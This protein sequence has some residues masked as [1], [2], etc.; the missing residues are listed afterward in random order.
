[1]LLLLRGFDRRPGR[2]ASTGRRRAFRPRLQLRR[3]LNIPQVR[4]FFGVQQ[5]RGHGAAHQH[6]LGRIG[7]GHG[8]ALIDGHGQKRRVHIGSGRHAEGN[9]GQPADSGQPLGFTI[10][11]GLQG[12]H[13][14]PGISPY[15][16]H[17]PVH[18]YVLPAHAQFQ[19][20][21]HNAVNDLLLFLQILGKPL[22]RQGQQNKHGAVFLHYGKQFFEFFRLIGYGI[23]QRTPG[24][25]TQRCLQHF[26]M[27]GVQR[28]RKAGHSLHLL[29]HPQHHGLLVYAA[30]PHIHIQNGGAA[31][32]L[33]LGKLEHHVHTA[34][35]KLFLQFFLTRG[36]DPFSHH[37]KG[38]LQTEC[39]SL[40]LAGEI[41][42]SVRPAR[43]RPGLS[44]LHQ[45]L[46]PR[47]VGG[48][49]PA[50]SPQDRGSRFHQFLHLF[51]K[52]I[53]IHIID[54]MSLPIHPGQSRVGLGDQRQA[55]DP[56]HSL[57]DPPHPRG[58]GGAVHPYGIRP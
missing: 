12:F 54:H 39:Q 15:G 51:H 50:A 31:G 5:I 55:A 58:A 18:H 24:I 41:A 3:I 17:Q 47:D 33:L 26:H 10:A 13:P 28:Q 44:P 29:Q 20:P 35:P 8:Q 25:M 38:I 21:V 34:L 11:D 53:A 4:P 36:I 9:I 46:K 37:H 48:I 16:G 56:G 14:C 19:S 57:H 6:F 32:F 40:A 7:D 30:H 43:P 42:D 2:S 45:T 23:D 52:S 49:R 1:M 27:A 22:V